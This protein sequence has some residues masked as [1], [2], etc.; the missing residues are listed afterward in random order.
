MKDYM[1]YIEIN[2]KVMFGKPVIKGNPTD[3]R[4]NFGRIVCRKVF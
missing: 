3:C 2:P 1:N 4:R